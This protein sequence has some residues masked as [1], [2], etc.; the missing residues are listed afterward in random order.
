M[1]GGV[2]AD[3]GRR[4]PSARGQ[5]NQSRGIFQGVVNEDDRS[6]HT[7]SGTAM[8]PIPCEGQSRGD[9]KLRLSIPT[10]PS[11]APTCVTRTGGATAPPTR[12]LTTARS[13]RPSSSLSLFTGFR[14]R[15]REDE[16]V[17][18]V[19][20]QGYNLGRKKGGIRQPIGSSSREDYAREAP[21]M[22]IRHRRRQTRS[23]LREQQD[24][25]RGPPVGVR[26]HGSREQPASELVN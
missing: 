12:S 8:E 9:A 26:S 5:R 10:T 1:G 6:G 17:T 20:D 7:C 14:G 23:P 22:R 15:L 11:H 13:Q 24:D 4:E 25:N 2:S 21:T 3:P 18:G 16:W 19:P